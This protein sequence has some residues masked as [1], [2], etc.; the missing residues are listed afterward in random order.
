MLHLIF[1]S[2]LLPDYTL[3]Q[4]QP[5]ASLTWAN[6][7]KYEPGVSGNVIYNNLQSPRGLRWDGAGHLLAIERQTGVIALEENVD[8]CQGWTKKVLIRNPA[9]NHGIHVEGREL[10]VSTPDEVLRFA[11]DPQ[12]VSV[13]GNATTLVTGMDLAESRYFIFCLCCTVSH[14]YFRS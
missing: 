6:E 13:E 10:Y 1:L 11:Y 14:L 12:A 4:C 8:G 5:R 7:P 3:A 9:F 2:L